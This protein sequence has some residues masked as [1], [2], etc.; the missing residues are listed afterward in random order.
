MQT[1]QEYY[2]E[3]QL[4]EFTWGQLGKGF[5]RVGKNIFGKRVTGVQVNMMSSIKEIDRSTYNF[6]Q[7]VLTKNF[8]SKNK[9]NEKIFVKDVYKGEID[10]SAKKLGGYEDIKDQIQD[11]SVYQTNRGGRITTF[12]LDDN[13]EEK[14]YIGTNWRGDKQFKDIFGMWITSLASRLNYIRRKGTT[15]NLEDVMEN[16]KEFLLPPTKPTKKIKDEEDDDEEEDEREIGIIDID[17]DEY[18]NL[19]RLWGNGRTGGITKGSYYPFKGKFTRNRYFSKLG[20]DGYKYSDKVGHT[21]YLIDIGD[22]KNAFIA[23]D[24]KESYS[25]AENIDML[26]YW[27]SKPGETTDIRWQSGTIEDL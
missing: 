23:F 21:V 4:N 6:V 8:M 25:W 3:V 19:K 26:D 14:F 1:F 27:R 17:K 13:G 18:Y 11:I 24:G 22:E 12:F 20:Y 9:K 15:K 7:G 2:K 5:L 16:P 10:D